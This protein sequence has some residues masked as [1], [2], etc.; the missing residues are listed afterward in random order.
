VRYHLRERAAEVW[1]RPIQAL[2]S[3]DG[4]TMGMA[5]RSVAIAAR[6]AVL[7]MVTTAD[8]P[9]GCSFHP[10]CDVVLDIC[11]SAAPT[12]E[13]ATDGR[14]LWTFETTV[15][16]EVPQASI[17]TD[18]GSHPADFARQLIAGVAAHRGRPTLIPFLEG[19]GQTVADEIPAEFF[20]IRRSA[21]RRR[22]A[23]SGEPVV[24]EPYVPWELA[25]VDPPSTGRHDSSAQT[26]V[27][28]WV[29]VN[30]VRPRRRR[31][32]TSPTSRS[33]PVCTRGA[34]RLVDAEAEAAAIVDR[35]SAVSSTPSRPDGRLPHWTPPADVLHSR[36]GSYATD[37]VL[38]GLILVDGDTLDP[39]AFKG[40]FARAARVL[41]R[42][43][44]AAATRSSATTPGSPRPSCTQVGVR[45]AV[46][47][48]RHRGQGSGAAFL[49]QRVR[50]S[51]TRK[52]S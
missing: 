32:S 7:G 28:R 12:L 44:S 6:A 27:G 29:L 13:S 21:P 47:D 26:S 5:V 33:C 11:D 41:E 46:V 25:A 42:A 18:I 8:P 48:R 23:G 10:R 14:L 17:A 22:A 19:I 51:T 16:A 43:R 45:A 40:A 52:S 1:S 31:R 24:E 34:W 9:G 2:F 37:G 30:V 39:M 4:Q 49:P 3:V 20:T 38:G 15:G 50:R 36:H 35:W